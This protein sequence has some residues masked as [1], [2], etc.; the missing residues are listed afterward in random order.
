MAAMTPPSRNAQERVR[1]KTALSDTKPANSNVHNSRDGYGNRS[2]AADEQIHERSEQRE[3]VPLQQR[4]FTI[5]S[6]CRI[7][8]HLESALRRA[9]RLQGSWVQP[10]N[11]HQRDH[12]DRRATPLQRTRSCAFLD[13]TQLDAFAAVRSGMRLRLFPCAGDVSPDTK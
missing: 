12:A 13:Q 10:K 8:H 7:V 4:L 5:V 11:L 3:A 1:A 9:H 6:A 2:D